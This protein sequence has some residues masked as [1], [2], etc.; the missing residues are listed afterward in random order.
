MGLFEQFPYTNFH[1]LNLDWLLQKVKQ[2]DSKVDSFEDDIKA[3]VE[4]WFEEH[5][6]I[7]I[8]D[9]SITVEKLAAELKKAYYESGQVKYLIPNFTDG[10]DTS[11]RG[12]CFLA[13]TPE[14]TILFDCGSASDWTCILNDFNRWMTEGEFSNI[15]IIVISHYHDD[16][17]SNLGDILDNFPHDGA[18]AY[19][20]PAADGAAGWSGISANMTYVENTLSAYDIPRNVISSD[21]TIPIST[22]LV[23]MELFNTT[24]G[25]SG[26]YKYYDNNDNNYNNYSMCALLTVGESFMMYCGDIQQT[27]QK[28][29]MA[30]RDLPHLAMYVIHHH[31]YQGDDFLPYLRT[32]D[33]DVAVNS[34]SHYSAYV[35]GTN[36]DSSTLSILTGQ[37]CSNAYG[38]VIVV[39]GTDGAH[40]TQGKVLER[41][42]VRE[43][44]TYLYVDNT[45]VGSIHDGTPEHPF[46][47]ICEAIAWIPP[48]G[49]VTTYI[50]VKPTAQTY[51][52]VW[53]LGIA[54]R[55][56]I[57]RWPD[58][59]GDVHVE[60]IYVRGCSDVYVTQMSFDGTGKKSVYACDTIAFCG[61]SNVIFYDCVFDGTNM[62]QSGTAP[63]VLLLLLSGI[64]SA[65][66][67]TFKNSQRGIAG[68]GAQG[69]SSATVFSSW[70]NNFDTLTDYGIECFYLQ[71]EYLGHGTITAT[72]YSL[73]TVGTYPSPVRIRGSAVTAASLATFDPKIVSTPFY[74]SSSY[75]ACIVRNQKCFELSGTERT[76]S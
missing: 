24:L 21:T 64:F 32:I 25:D 42:A 33:P 69:H 37:L 66:N 55:V 39:Q 6:E 75:M 43:F 63:D 59:V 10:T 36:E 68:A 35:A 74:K 7:Q 19:V 47:E 22:G 72:P 16:H 18:V 13:V 30:T 20:P 11:M 40:I 53:L 52:Y 8:P 29:I 38:S 27:A 70:S 76:V 1:E 23:T 71:V 15:D 58:T 61:Q 31:A 4:E 51:R 44:D 17:V 12:T 26:D 56:F 54:S 49:N 48:A 62:A 65:R 28:R 60:G 50:S 73:G 41:G 57:R 9:D 45:Y 5:P 2:L 34:N 14:K 67:C 3:A 46:T